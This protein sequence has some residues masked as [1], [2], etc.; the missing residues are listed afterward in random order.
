MASSLNPL[1]R[2]KVKDSELSSVQDNVIRSVAPILQKVIIDGQILEDISIA[3]GAVRN[4]SHG[5]GRPITGYFIMKRNANAQIWDSEATNTQKDIYLKLN[6]SA[7]C[8]VSIWV[9]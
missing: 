8:I 2:L 9:F 6:S 3:T 1:E 7:N 4:I 5:L